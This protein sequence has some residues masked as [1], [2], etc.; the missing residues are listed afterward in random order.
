MKTE[1]ERHIVWLDCDTGT[2][3]A[4]AI[5]C[6]NALPE[7]EIV[8]ISAVAGNVELEKT[9]RNALRLNRL[10]GTDYPVYQG[11]E[12][13]WLQPQHTG[14]RYH[15][16]NGLGGVELPLPEDVIVPDVPAWD[17][18][19]ACARSMPGEL[20]LVATAPMTNIATAFIRYPDLPG[21][22][23]SVTFM[24]G[25]AG[26]GNV[27]PAAE[28]NFYTDPEAAQIVLQ[29]GAKLVMCGLDVT[30][31]AYYS[32]EQLESM[33]ATGSRAGTFVRDCGRYAW[34]VFGK[35]G[36]AGFSMHDSCP[37]M[38][39]AHPELFEGKMA[40]M[41]V[42]TRGT[43]TNGKSV[44]DLYSDK[45]FPFKNVLVLLKVDRDRFISILTDCVLGIR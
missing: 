25:S 33:A 15:G 1:M 44:T 19:Y 36:M 10:M 6:A 39:L 17:A 16:E 45:Q 24:G 28:F 20:R 18:L 2:D 29:S 41:A 35:L 5:L 4:Q 30:N 23:H 13:P 38:Y 40:G 7:L 14:Y 11:A 42:E 9:Y 32:M 12:K 34:S 27:T 31:Q 26:S 21:L 22:L 43:V 8:A 3:D 37:V